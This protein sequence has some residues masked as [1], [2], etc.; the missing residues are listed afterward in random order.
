MTDKLTALARHS[1]IV[2]DSGEI[3]TLRS[4]GAQDCTTNPSLI[5]RAAGKPE[6]ARLLKD[7]VVWAGQREND[8]GRRVNLALDRVAVNFGAELSRV[9]PGYVST[10]VDARLSFDTAVT[11][12]RAE[13]LIALYQEVGVD[14]SRILIKV[15]ATWEGVKAAAELTRKGMKCNLTLVFGMSQAALCGEAGVFLI[16]PFVGRIT[17]W[18]VAHGN[19]PERA[20][21]DLGVR[22]VREI[23]RYYKTLGLQTVVMAASFRNTGQVLALAGCDRLTISPALLEQLHAEEGAVPRALDPDDRAP[24]LARVAVDE[25][26]F[27]WALNQDA[28]ATEKLS[29]GIRLFARDTETLCDLIRQTEASLS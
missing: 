14:T 26:A 10:E 25:V 29:E 20:A 13:R 23:Y 28:M 22:S 9:V 27:R 5:L 24:G 1:V 11:V 18:H 12:A 6:Y 16:S 7:A 8:P 4:L 3:D 19:K 17:D 15:A 21:D 2:A